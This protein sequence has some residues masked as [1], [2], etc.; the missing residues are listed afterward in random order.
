MRRLACSIIV[1]VACIAGA[2]ATPASAAAAPSACTI[3][4]PQISNSSF[5]GK[6]IVTWVAAGGFYT[7]RA[8][9][10]TR[11]PGYTASV[12]YRTAST[13]PH[14]IASGS[15]YIDWTVNSGKNPA[16]GTVYIPQA[17]ASWSWA[18]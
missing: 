8:V 18:I 6:F 17:N 3:S 13:G 16:R 14:A 9:V 15:A 12:S 11:Q 10:Q 1:A 2:V 5:C 7:I 4:N